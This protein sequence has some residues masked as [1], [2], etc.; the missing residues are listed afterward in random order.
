M[1]RIEDLE[2]LRSE[3]N[4]GFDA[5]LKEAGAKAEPEVPVFKPASLD[6]DR[7]KARLEALGIN[8]FEAAK[9]TGKHEHF[10]YDFF[11]GRKKSFPSDGPL[12]LA[13]ALQCSIEYLAGVSDEVGSPPAADWLGHT[14]Q[15]PTGE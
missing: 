10:I 1:V 14:N 2:R 15:Q 5:L 4:S 11:K 13:H 6:P 8:Q 7:I 9:R 3:V 12:R